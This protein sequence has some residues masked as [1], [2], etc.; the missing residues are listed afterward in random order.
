MYAVQAGGNLDIL[1]VYDEIEFLSTVNGTVKRLHFQQQV[2]LLDNQLPYIF[3]QKMNSNRQYR[4]T[5]ETSRTIM[6]FPLATFEFEVNLKINADDHVF[7]GFN[8]GS[9][10]SWITTAGMN[11]NYTYSYY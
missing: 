10:S 8:T 2:I 5:N 1:L 9:G 3:Q 7:V 6:I 11:T 4:Y